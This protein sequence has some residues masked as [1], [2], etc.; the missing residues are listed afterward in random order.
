MAAEVK[1]RRLQATGRIAKN[2]GLFIA[3]PFI[4]L[5]YVIA[6]PA[7]GF[8]MFAKLGYE[9]YQKRRVPAESGCNGPLK[10]M[11]RRN[12]TMISKCSR[13]SRKDPMSVSGLAALLAFGLMMAFALASMPAFASIDEGALSD[14]DAKCLKCHSKKL[15][16][17]MEDGEKLSLHVATADFT[18]SVHSGIGCTGCHED[19]ANRKHPKDQD[20]HQQP[21]RLLSCN[22]PG[23]WQLP[24]SEMQ[25][26]EGSIHA[27]LVADGNHAAP[28]CTD[29]HSA[30]AVQ[31]QA[32][33]EPVTGQSCKSCHETFSK[34]TRKACMARPGPTAT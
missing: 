12:L 25:Q 11:D 26:Y 21:A 29:C 27:S 10:A 6:L 8:Y 5:A 31:A 3:A 17:S 34:P 30:H 2:I 4:A 28:V 23:L 13:G 20:R 24:R 18:D 19:I 14:G 22:E 16:K 32:L 9:A 1:T 7:V 33:Y 15:K